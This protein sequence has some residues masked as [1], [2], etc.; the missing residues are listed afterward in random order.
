MLA[1]RKWRI[2]ALHF[3]CFFSRI[4]VKRVGNKRQL[5]F[6]SNLM[7]SSQILVEFVHVILFCF[8][9][10]VLSVKKYS[11]TIKQRWRFCF[12]TAFMDSK[13]QIVWKFYTFWNNKQSLQE[14]HSQT[15]WN[16]NFYSLG[17]WIFPCPKWRWMTITYKSAIN[18][19]I[20]T[21]PSNFNCKFRIFVNNFLQYFIA[22]YSK[23]Y[24]SV[25]NI[26][27]WAVR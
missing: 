20:S 12:E 22:N 4:Q 18:S 6:H 26:Q 21:A 5:I 19:Q 2:I 3:N 7:V 23:K 1:S 24:I 15:E 25:I 27:R 9:C 8:I 17:S 16:L 13:M 10:M 11:E 14:T